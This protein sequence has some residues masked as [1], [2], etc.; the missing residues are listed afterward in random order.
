VKVPRFRIAWLMVF[1]AIAALDFRAIRA[2]SDIRSRT[3]NNGIDILVLGALPM[4]NVL[5]VG[6]L[7]SLRRRGHRP[8]LL[9]FEAFGAAA[10]VL[11]I[12]LVGFF[13]EEAVMPYLYLILKPLERTI[14]LHT[15]IFYSIT[16]VMLGLP[17][18]AFALIGGV[19]SRQVGIVERPD[20]TY[21]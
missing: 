3:N 14:G 4:A 9:G 20:R 5:A 2:V 10:L 16:A 13:A 21:C 18:L 6:L 15:P 17:Q 11:Y 12:A 8:F 7:T 19:L 1:V